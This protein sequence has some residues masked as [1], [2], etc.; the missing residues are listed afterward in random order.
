M[1]RLFFALAAFAAV[2]AVPAAANTNSTRIVR[3]ADL[4]LGSAVGRTRLDQR[5]QAAAR[6]LCGAAAPGDLAVAGAVRD[7]RV[8][9]L[10]QIARP[11]A[12]PLAVAGA[13]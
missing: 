2:S 9:T 12:A 3:Y 7:C 13:R 5:L 10:A 6:E 8:A 4:D 1:S 11:S